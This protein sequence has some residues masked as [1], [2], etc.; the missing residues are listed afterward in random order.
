MLDTGKE[1]R[2]FRILIMKNENIEHLFEKFYKFDID[3]KRFILK[4]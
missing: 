1:R 4:V 2:T 3:L